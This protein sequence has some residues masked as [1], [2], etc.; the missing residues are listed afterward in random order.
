MGMSHQFGNL[1]Q[2]TPYKPLILQ[3]DT[4]CPYAIRTGRRLRT[5]IN[6][7]NTNT[8]DRNTPND[9]RVDQCLSEYVHVE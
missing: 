2:N 4:S 9:F 1:V 8:G 6:Y 7:A 3:N 5:R